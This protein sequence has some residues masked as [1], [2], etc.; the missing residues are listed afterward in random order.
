V[1]NADKQDSVAA[2]PQITPIM[3]E[4]GAEVIR[5]EMYDLDAAQLAREVF[6]AMIA[7]QDS[8]LIRDGIGPLG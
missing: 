2:T 3:A 6:A 7:A 8:R 1:P 5:A 4:A